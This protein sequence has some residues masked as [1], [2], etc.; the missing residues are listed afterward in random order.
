MS[1]K[2]NLLLAAALVTTGALSN[3]AS[4]QLDYRILAT[5]RTSTMEKELNQASADGYR[6]SKVMGGR[7][8]NGGQEVAIA[9]VKYSASP[10]QAVPAYK[11]LATSKT[12]TMQKELQQW[13]DAGY[14]YLDQ[15][16]FETAFGGKEVVVIMERD[17]A[18]PPRTS[19]YRLLATTKTSTMEKELNEAAR[20]G[21][22]L[23]GFSV[24]KTQ[25][26]GDEIISILKMTPDNGAGK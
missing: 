21:F 4:A 15:T 5:S 1:P 23:V 18:R 26:G 19:S 20:S 24:G 25:I 22:L 13:A 11:L 12:S 10:D 16:V 17:A 6:F 2:S 8:A 9:M 7:T 3:I 14:D